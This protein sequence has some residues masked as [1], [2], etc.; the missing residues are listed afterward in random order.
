[1]TAL[2]KFQEDA[3]AHRNGYVPDNAVKIS[4]LGF[5]FKA[6]ILDVSHLEEHLDIPLLTMKSDDLLV[7]KIKLGGQNGQ[8]L[9]YLAVADKD[10]LHLLLLFRLNH[11]ALE[12]IRYL[13]MQI[14]GKCLPWLARIA[15]KANQLSIRSLNP[16]KL[17]FTL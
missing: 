5:P 9:A 17:R 2:L 12:R 3:V 6:E 4:K 16:F 15:G 13:P 10:D 1:M 7:D 8:P 11:H 14:T